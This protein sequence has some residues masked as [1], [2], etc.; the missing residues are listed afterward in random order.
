MIFIVVRFTTLP[1]H[2]GA[3]LSRV[4]GFTQAT[5]AEPGNLW[6]E[7]SRSVEHPDQFVLV[8]AFRDQDAG[9]AHVGSDHFRAAMELMPS[10]LARTPDIV[11]TEVDQAGWGEMGELTVP[12]RTP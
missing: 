3:W 1:E 4:D 9:A 10:M 6:F 8:E 5:R 7:W 2:T 12:V 11:S